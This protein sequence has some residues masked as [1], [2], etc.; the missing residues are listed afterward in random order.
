MQGNTEN[1]FK[2]SDKSFVF[3]NFS[4]SNSLYDGVMQCKS[5]QCCTVV[6]SITHTCTVKQHVV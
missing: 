5:L 2:Y 1:G 3:L 6:L 4:D